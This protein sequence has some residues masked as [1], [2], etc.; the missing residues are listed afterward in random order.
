MNNCF[1]SHDLVMI[2]YEDPVKTNDVN[3]AF[4]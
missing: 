3:I 2:F 1:L 4:R